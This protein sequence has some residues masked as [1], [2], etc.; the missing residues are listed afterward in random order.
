MSSTKLK[1]LKSELKVEKKK[2]EEEEEHDD[3]EQAASLAREDSWIA[4]KPIEVGANEAIVNII[5]LSV[6][7][8]K[9]YDHFLHII[10]II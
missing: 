2:Q 8:D 7:Y 6:D 1:D 4:V 5:S 3:D 10:G 9:V